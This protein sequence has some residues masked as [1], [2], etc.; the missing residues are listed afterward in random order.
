MKTRLA[1]LF[2]FGSVAALVAGCPADATLDPGL[3]KYT[4][5][6]IESDTCG[7]PN[8]VGAAFNVEFV[9]SDE[10]DNDYL[11]VPVDGSGAQACTLDASGGLTCDDRD[12]IGD[13][14]SQGSVIETHSVVGDSGEEDIATTLEGTDTITVDCHSGVCDE[15]PGGFP[16]EIV[17]R[18]TA[19]L[20]TE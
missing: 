9:V 13:G 18:F 15:P 7:M 14:G 19:E 5:A 8:L 17:V 11:F 16:C 6:T 10:G 4:S 20:A 2:L 1:S 3:W 12:R